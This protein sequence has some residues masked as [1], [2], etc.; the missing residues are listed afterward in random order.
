MN[1]TRTIF[2]GIAFMAADNSAACANF[3]GSAEKTVQPY[4]L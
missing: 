1:W 4:F 2:D 3:C